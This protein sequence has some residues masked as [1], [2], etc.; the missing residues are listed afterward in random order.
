MKELEIEI[1]RKIDLNI[2]WDETFGFFSKFRSQS[3][4]KLRSQDVTESKMLNYKYLRNIMN[5]S[6][7]DNVNLNK[8]CEYWKSFWI[9]YY[10]YW[11]K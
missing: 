4:T 2:H 11:R 7:I 3:V 9:K 6:C 8:D 5:E 1:E 10:R